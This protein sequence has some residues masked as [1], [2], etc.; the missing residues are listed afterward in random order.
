MLQKSIISL[1]E[2][3]LLGVSTRTNNRAE[4]NPETAKIS[5][6]IQ[7]FFSEGFSNQ[8]MDR[9][10][11]G[12]YF[13]VY[14]DYASDHTGDYTY[15]FGEEVS[16]LQSAVQ[17]LDYI[18]IPAQKY[19]K[20]TTLAGAVPDIVIAAWQEIWAMNEDMLGGK[21]SYIGDFEIYDERRSDR[22][23]AVVDIYVGIK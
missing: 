5:M 13:S 11:P 8:I 9:S 18:V 17:G 23:N 6:T 4:F 21:R 15:L 16:E 22:S 12:T 10:Q 3:K 14:S 19:A 7:K 20:F 2:I 1:P